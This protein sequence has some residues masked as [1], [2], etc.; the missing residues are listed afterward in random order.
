M[1]E[2]LTHCPSD[3]DGHPIKPG[4][5]VH[6]HAT[7]LAVGPENIAVEV[8]DPDQPLGP[9]RVVVCKPCC[10]HCDDHPEH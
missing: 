1:P 3:C 5:K 10:V 2:A 6:V 7:V 4:C 8:C 9:Y